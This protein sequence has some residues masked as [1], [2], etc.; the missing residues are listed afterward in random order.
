MAEALQEDETE[1]KHESEQEALS[2]V[3]KDVHSQLREQLVS[4]RSTEVD[5]ITCSSQQ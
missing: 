5:Y 4:G 1:E 3:V 2:S